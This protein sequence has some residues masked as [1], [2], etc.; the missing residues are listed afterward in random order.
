MTD[1]KKRCHPYFYYCHYEILS[2]S[3]DDAQL[4]QEETF[5]GKK[6]SRKLPEVLTYSKSGR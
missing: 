5:P 3:T 4:K 1:I 6:P 2:S